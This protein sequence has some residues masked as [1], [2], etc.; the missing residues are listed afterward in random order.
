MLESDL[1]GEEFLRHVASRPSGLVA[2]SVRSAFEAWF[3]VELAHMLLTKGLGSVRFGYDY[4]D[5][6]QKADLACE[7]ER[8]LSVFELK[9]FVRGAD[10]NKMQTWPDQLNRL[11]SLVQKGG[12]AQGLA[13]STYFEYKQEK[14]ADVISRFHHLPWRRLGPRKF[15]ENAPLYMVVGSVT[16]AD[17]SPRDEVQ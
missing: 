9:C 8:G 3:Q 4:P 5:S 6:R 2:C 12:A 15:F 1:V 16:L 10:A 17:V 7:G 14:M 11:L 13:V